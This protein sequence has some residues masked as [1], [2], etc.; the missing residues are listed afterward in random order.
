MLSSL[1]AKDSTK[2]EA[3]VKFP[4]PL[5]SPRQRRIALLSWPYRVIDVVTR[6]RDPKMELPQLLAVIIVLIRHRIF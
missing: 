5:K 2:S 6:E 4:I 1:E 3:E